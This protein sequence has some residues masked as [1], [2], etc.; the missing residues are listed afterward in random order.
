[1][2]AGKV[3]YD[4]LVSPGSFFFK[5]VKPCRGVQLTTASFVCKTKQNKEASVLFCRKRQSVVS[6][7]SRNEFDVLLTGAVSVLLSVK[8]L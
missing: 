1:M 6:A 4:I 2:G 8:V 7:F 3:Y 5:K